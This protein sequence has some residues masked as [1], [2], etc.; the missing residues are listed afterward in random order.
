M[1]IHDA[2]WQQLNIRI[3]QRDAFTQFS[4]TAGFGLNVF[5]YINNKWETKVAKKI[6]D[7]EVGEP[8]AVSLEYDREKE[9][10][11]LK[12]DCLLYTSPSP[13]DRTRSRMPSSA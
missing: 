5:E 2:G 12:L 8:L 1:T 13:R 9:E 7:I 4:V 6:A 10:A 3:G 11:I